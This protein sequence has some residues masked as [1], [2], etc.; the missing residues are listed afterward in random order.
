M[1]LGLKRQVTLATAI[2]VLGTTGLAIAAAP[3]IAAAIAARKANYKEIGGDMK[4]ISDEIKT[5]AP[6]LAS[7]RSAARDLV[8]RA[9]GQLKYFPAGS[10]PESGEKT[11]AKAAIWTDYTTFGTAQSDMLIAAKA[12]Q[13]ATDGGDLA[14]MTAARNT[15]GNACKACHDKFRELE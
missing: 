12:L 11:R 13:I 5:G 4:T 14:S 6:D 7:V 2:A 3:E 10:G 8:N 1:R 15:L 9:S